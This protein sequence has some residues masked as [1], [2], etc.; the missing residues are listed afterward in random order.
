[1][2]VLIQWVTQIILF[3]LL[4]AI[5]DLLVPSNSM[6]KYIKLVVGLILILILL[7]PIFY[8]FQIDINQALEASVAQFEQETTEGK[9]M[10]NLIESQKNEI[11]DAQDA[12]ILEQMAVQLK[13]YAEQ[14]LQEEYQVEITDIKFQFGNQQEMTFKN[15][16]EVIVY[17]RESKD[18]EGAV[19]IVD[20][21]VIDTD[22]PDN[23]NE[24]EQ[25]E[26]IQA[27]LREVWELDNKKV[28]LQWEG[29]AP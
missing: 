20:D 27:L 7:K 11:E 2:Q 25:L 26:Q 12:Y 4:A 3:L 1:M 14:P 15:L 23:T 6:K 28:T 9:S 18:G 8:I 24:D 16:D 22:N 19:S 17:L 5:I 10:E 29:G 13:E 21:V